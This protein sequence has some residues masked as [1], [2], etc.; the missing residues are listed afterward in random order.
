MTRRH[1]IMPPELRRAPLPILVFRAR[2][3]MERQ[4]VPPGGVDETYL[5]GD[6]WK[7]QR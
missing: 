4:V 1:W 5:R 7:G 2:Y 3:R 6:R